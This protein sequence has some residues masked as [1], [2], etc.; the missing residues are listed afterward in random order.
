FYSELIYTD[1]GSGHADFEFRTLA[2]KY[3]VH[4]Y[5]LHYI[6]SINCVTGVQVGGNMSI[7]DACMSLE[8]YERIQAESALGPGLAK[9]ATITSYTNNEVWIDVQTD[10]P[11]WLIFTDSYFPGW[12]AWI[13]PLGGD[14]KS[15]KSVPIELVDG[16]FR[17]IR[18]NDPGMYTIRMKYSP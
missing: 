3:N 8:E 11:R 4:Q 17:G 2:S 6:S 14:D 10:E 9:P 18:I 16:N 15:E 13:R 7:G 5:I 12:R 1:T